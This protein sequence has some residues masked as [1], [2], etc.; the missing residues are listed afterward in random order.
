[1]CEYKC[2]HRGNN[3]FLPRSSISTLNG[4]LA[5]YANSNANYV[6]LKRHLAQVHDIDVKCF[7]CDIYEFKC[8]ERNIDKTTSCLQAQHCDKCDVK[9]K[10]R[11][12]LKEHLANKHNIDLPLEIS[13][14]ALRFAS[15]SFD[16]LYL[17]VRGQAPCP[18]ASAEAPP[19]GRNI[20]NH[21]E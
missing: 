4:L 20:V 14:V 15:M 3:D 7:S 5:T 11:G 9:C 1:M 10:T 21:M 19:L 2:K 17:A 18:S 8:K 16:C 12:Q 13:S 6:D